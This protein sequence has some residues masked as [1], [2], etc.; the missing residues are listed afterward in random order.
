M[1]EWK[2]KLNKM[3][4]KKFSILISIQICSVKTI[5]LIKKALLSISKKKQTNS[6]FEELE[7]SIK[8]FFVK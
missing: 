7:N 8:S 2:I 4:K 3:F 5:K 1:F 6:Y